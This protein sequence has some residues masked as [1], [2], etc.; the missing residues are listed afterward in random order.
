M[1]IA[2]VAVFAALGVFAAL[3]VAVWVASVRRARRSAGPPEPATEEGLPTLFQ[4][5]I[6]FVVT[7]FDTLGIGSF[8]TT[9]SVYKLR[10]VVPDQLIPG[11]LNVGITAPTVAQALI[12]I[13][14]IRA[15]LRTLALMIAAA[16]AGAWLGAGIVAGWPR[17]NIQI[18]MGVALLLAAILMLSTQ[19]ALFPVGG[20][21]LGVSGARMAI[22]LLGNFALGALMTLGIGLYAP[23]MI[24]VSLLGMNPAVAFP[25]MMGSCAFLMPVASIRFIRKRR[26]ALRAALGLTLGGIPA[27]LLAAFIV[28][29]LP[30]GA[31]RWLV[32]CVVLYTAASM[33]RSARAEAPTQVS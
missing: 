19:L 31:V 21:A 22:A 2:L 18:G 17:R 5:A 27:V 16:V 15:D 20:D 8:A 30:L 4:T 25:I 13:S 24:L 1:P 14:I 28:R 33:L 26:Y 29:S 7:F 32:V 23:C 9:T 11:T 12:Y 6:G 3:F 10:Q